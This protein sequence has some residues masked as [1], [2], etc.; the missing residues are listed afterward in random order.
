M[1][2][3]DTSAR[4]DAQTSLMTSFMARTAFMLPIRMTLARGG[5]TNST[6]SGGAAEFSVLFESFRGGRESDGFCFGRM[7][8]HGMEQIMDFEAHRFVVKEADII[9][10]YS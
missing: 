7:M 9:D 8:R 2:I 1:I 3:P 6:L 5:L 4:R 10:Q